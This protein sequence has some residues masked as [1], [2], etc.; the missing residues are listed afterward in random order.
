MSG[1]EVH[2]RLWAANERLSIRFDWAVFDSQGLLDQ[3]VL[4]PLQK[5]FKR[6]LDSI[7]EIIERTKL[8]SLKASL[9]PVNPN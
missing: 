5:S 6:R 1:G 9:C 3:H 4:S 8:E 7:Q 2:Q